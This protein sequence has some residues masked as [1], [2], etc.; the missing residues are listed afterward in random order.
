MTAQPA[1]DL[2]VAAGTNGLRQAQPVGQVAIPPLAVSGLVVTK[3]ALLAALRLYV[4][5]VTDI[6]ALADDRFVLVVVGA[7]QDSTP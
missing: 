4:P 1:P 2:A 6:E 3:A 7:G 5:Q